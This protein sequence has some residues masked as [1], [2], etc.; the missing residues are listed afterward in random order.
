MTAPIGRAAKVAVIVRVS[1]GMDRPKSFATVGNTNTSTKKS[2]AS[3]VQP[4]NP[5]AIAYR[6]FDRAIAGAGGTEAAKFAIR[7]LVYQHLRPAGRCGPCGLYEWIHAYLTVQGVG[8]Q[9]EAS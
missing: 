1:S 3:K 5:A 9:P 7:Q 4:R 6:A 2:K 8:F